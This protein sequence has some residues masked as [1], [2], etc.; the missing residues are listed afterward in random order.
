MDGLPVGRKKSVVASANMTT[1]PI[2]GPHMAATLAP[3]F[4]PNSVAVES[5]TSGEVQVRFVHHLG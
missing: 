4:P 5:V 1:S 2:R 3:Q